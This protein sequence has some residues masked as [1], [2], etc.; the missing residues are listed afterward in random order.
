MNEA[1]A[2]TQLRHAFAADLDLA[3]FAGHIRLKVR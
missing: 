1:Q 3:P 2:I